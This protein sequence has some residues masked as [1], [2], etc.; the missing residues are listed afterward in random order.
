MSSPKEIL[1]KLENSSLFKDWHGQHKNSYLSHFF[2][3]MAS[4]LDLKSNW[5]IGFY[6]KDSNKITVFVAGEKFSVKAEDEVFKK[7]E[8]IVE[9]LDMDKVKLTLDKASKACK[10]NFSKLFPNEQFGDGFI[11]LQTIKEKALWNFS[12]ITKTLKFANVKIDSET[13]ELNS[14][15]VVELVQK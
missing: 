13:G 11:I 12:L 6:D 14:H 8:D 15:E 10:E 7:D 4:N 9:R 2:S 3:Q 1:E 5:E